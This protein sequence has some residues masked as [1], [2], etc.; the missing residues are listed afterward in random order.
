M[1]VLGKNILIAPKKVG[2]KKTSYGLELSEKHRDKERYEEATVLHIG[3]EVKGVEVGDKIIYDQASGHF[4]DLEGQ[5][6]QVRVI[7]E[8]DVILIL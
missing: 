1:R 4:I 2:I 6:E 7:R 5:E 3:E 8:F